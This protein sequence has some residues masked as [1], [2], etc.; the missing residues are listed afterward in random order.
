MYFSWWNG[1]T[2]VTLDG[3]SYASPAVMMHWYS[4]STFWQVALNV[5]LQ[6]RPNNSDFKISWLKHIDVLVW[7]NFL[8]LSPKLVLAYAEDIL[9]DSRLKNCAKCKSGW[10]KLQRVHKMRCSAVFWVAFEYSGENKKKEVILENAPHGT[11]KWLLSQNANN[12]F[13][14]KSE[15]IVQ[16]CIWAL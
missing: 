12:R 3:F 9:C 10:C 13:Y 2:N 1:E 4:K 14:P 11:P 7:K 15:N 8:I 6:C 16:M 5:N